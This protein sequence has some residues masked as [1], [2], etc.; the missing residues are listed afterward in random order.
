MSGEAGSDH[1]TRPSTRSILHAD[2]DAFF[3]SVEQLHDPSLAG[4][5]VIVG[6][7]GNR[8]V[9]AAASY[10]ARQFGVHSAMPMA[11]ARRACPDGV[12]LAPRFE[13][14]G[15]ASRAVMEVFEGI[16]PLVEP[17]ALDEAFLD[18]SGARRLLGGPAE[19]AAE[20]RERVK[21]TTGLVVSVGGATTKH[22]AKLASQDA[23]PDGVLILDA[24]A[25]LAFVQ[26][27]PVGR[28]WGVGPATLKKL[29]RL[30]V[31]TVAD[32]VRLPDGAL[33]TAIGPG[34]A[35]HLLALAV[36]A[37]D[38][39]IETER[40]AKSVG[41]E[42]TFARDVFSRERLHVEVVRLSE[43][44][45]RRLRAAGLMART[46]VLKARYP[47]FSTVTRSRTL[48]DATDHAATVSGV[49]LELLDDVETGRGLRL[50]GVSTANLVERSGSQESLDLTGE[51]DASRRLDITV[52]E[53][54]ERFGDEAVGPA[55]L[56]GPRGLRVGRGGSLY[57]PDR[58]P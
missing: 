2:L 9:V 53:L 32:L 18:V 47:D 52:D 35:D 23:K 58:G 13:A 19:I 6:G 26:R 44:V 29:E 42:E 5:P 40:T 21:A 39:H 48:T 36:N 12:F 22:V 54:R 34:R 7:L 15:E 24:D 16:T 41:H 17:L 43:L 46:V 28:L 30:G 38:R 49:V 51:N 56:A 11:R 57:G 33:E 55:R 3:A 50:M 10:E 20:L 4:R 45:A 1:A 14:Y 25:E 27:L 31:D 8:G 37:D